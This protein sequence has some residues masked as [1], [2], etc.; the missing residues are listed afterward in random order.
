MLFLSLFAWLFVLL[1][2]DD[3]VYVDLKINILEDSE[4]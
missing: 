3:R 1:Q 2:L 4:Q